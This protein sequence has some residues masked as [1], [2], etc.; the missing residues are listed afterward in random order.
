MT[1][2]AA[3]VALASPV[4][5][6]ADES[7]V[8]EAAPAGE[9]SDP[10]IAPALT[11]EPL[12]IE[13]V[14]EGTPPVDSTESSDDA[15]PEEPAEADVAPTAVEPEPI[16]T[17]PSPTIAALDTSGGGEHTGGAGGTGDPYRMTFEVSWELP[18]GS[19]VLEVPTNWRKM[20]D[21]AAASATGGGK[22]TSAHCTYPEGSTDLVCEFQNPGMHASVTDGMVVPRK[23]TATY[24]VTVLWPVSGW[25]IDGAN[26][27]AYSARD[28]CTGGGH[29]GG[30]GGSGGH[31]SGHGETLEAAALEDSGSPVCIH[32]VVMRQPRPDSERPAE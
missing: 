4:V 25:T 29:G 6:V 1:A 16:G 30:G 27:D 15:V 18:D 5:A 10:T 17:D 7:E 9:N 23:S 3:G 11:T 22:P 2:T 24:T 28:V 8:I 20:F 26:A 13:L 14:V 21:L 19:P 32:T 31:D 12:T